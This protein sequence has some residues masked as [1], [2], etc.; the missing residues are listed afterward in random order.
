MSIQSRIRPELW[1]S[2]CSTY[3]A[4]NYA[5]AVL[6]AVQCMTDALRE[7]AVIDGDGVQL[8]N[9]ALGGQEPR[10]RLNKLQTRSERDVQDGYAHLLRGIYLGI[11]NPRS[12]E[13]TSDDQ[14][15]ADAI[16]CFVDHL[17][18][19]IPGSEQLWSVER[20]LKRA[21]DEHFV[22]S[23][24][25]AQLLVSEVP[26]PKKL[27]ALVHVF[28]ARESVDPES[29]RLLSHALLDVL[30]EQDETDF[31]AAVTREYEAADLS[32]GSVRALFC[33]LRPAL[34]QK[35][36]R[37]TRTRLENRIITALQE[38]ACYTGMH[39]E[40]IV[41]GALATWARAFMPFFDSR[42]TVCAR[43]CDK[44]ASDRADDRAYVAELFL[45]TLVSTAGSRWRMQSAGHAIADAI[46]R[47]DDRLVKKEVQRL[48]WPRD[49]LSMLRQELAEV[50]ESDPGYLA[51][52]QCDDDC[53]F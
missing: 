15:S 52:V 49:W 7:R 3:S 10:L 1:E 24:A 41:D 8:V 14:R 46:L 42:E 5:H 12:H 30:S 28:R 23:E 36:G 44:L 34:W 29:L 40:R 51:T 17:L 2:V 13:Q 27:E 33:I 20:F 53:P 22:R 9:Q 38:G 45:P 43:L 18:R 39:G 47:R 37:A 21:H 11:R 19:M 50:E 4:G 6:D 25:Y 16:I 35:V 32:F 31:V 48:L 26:T